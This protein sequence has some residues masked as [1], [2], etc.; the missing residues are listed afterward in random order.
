MLADAF[1]D[2]PAWMAIGPAREHARLRLLRAYYRVVLRETAAYGGPA[3]C[4]L[5]D[6]A[7]IG[8]AVT[9]A[10]GLAYPPPRA[11]IAEG[12]P[13]VTAGP[14]PAIRGAR[15]D[16]IFKRLHLH[17]PHLY[18]WQL[19]AHPTA[20]RQGVGRALMSR[21]LEEAERREAPAYLETTKPENVP[22][23]AGFGFRVVDE[24]ELPRGAHV[25]FMLRELAQRH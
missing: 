10:D 24:A 23:Y 2:D 3:W 11:L 18:L 19:A 17:E 25:W 22:Y 16:A 20:Q 5:R 13:F 9:F 1:L 7:V 14:G 21:V 15:V 8:V 6:G 12:V 4:A